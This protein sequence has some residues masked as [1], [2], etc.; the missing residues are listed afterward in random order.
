MASRMESSSEAV[1]CLPLVVLETKAFPTLPGLAA[2]RRRTHGVLVH[3][4]GDE[5]KEEQSWP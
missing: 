1:A 4:L 5:R 2:E 3:D